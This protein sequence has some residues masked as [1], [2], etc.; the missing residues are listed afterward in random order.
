MA[1]AKKLDKKELKQPD[2]F[3]SKG[4]KALDH[5]VQNK[6]RYLTYIAAFLG[7]V[8]LV[9][10][11][12]AF[13][14]YR[15]GKV[16][17]AFSDAMKVVDAEV[18]EDKTQAAEAKEMTFESEEAKNLAITT[19]LGEFI[20]KHADSRFATL[21]RMHVGNAFF[22]LKRYDKALEN[23]ETFLKDGDFAQFRFM[24]LN[25]IAQCQE[26]QGNTDQA[27]AT[28]KKIIDESKTDLW[29]DQS[30]YALGVLYKKQGNNDESI[31]WFDKLVEKYPESGLKT[32]ADKFL[33]VL[34]GPEPEKKAEEKA[35][36]PE[37]A[38]EKK[39]EGN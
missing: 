8:I 26:N 24:A 22:A 1:K 16:S 25:N 15:N 17:T 2:A 7:L 33:A 38:D 3:Q 39:G 6:K 4:E 10:V 14:D 9:Q 36:E 37:A 31:K 21:A 12:F 29:K 35:A 18:I 28:Y 30:F 20:N 32:K 23:Y 27:I 13:R 34:R 5:V 11:G 19:Q